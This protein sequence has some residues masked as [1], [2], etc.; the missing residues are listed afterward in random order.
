MGSDD[1]RP[2]AGG[3]C[4]QPEEGL[5][6]FPPTTAANTASPPAERGTVPLSARLRPEARR[7]VLTALL[8]LALTGVLTGLN[9]RRCLVPYLGE[10]MY[11]HDRVR[12]NRAHLYYQ[13]D[14]YLVTIAA[15]ALHDTTGVPLLTIFG[16][17]V[18][19]GYGAALA[20]LAYWLAGVYDDP[21]A[22]A[23]GLV[24]GAVYGA[25]MIPFSYHHPSDMFG[26]GM[27]AWGLGLMVRDRPRLLWLVCLAA[28]LFSIKQM[29]LAP[30]LLLTYALAGRWRRGAWLAVPVVLASEAVPIIYR[31][32][33][34]PHRMSP[35]GIMGISEWLEHLPRGL[36]VQ[37][38]LAGPPLLVLL[39]RRRS[40]PAAVWGALTVY[41]A[42]LLSLELK[43]NIIHEARTFWPGVPG[44]A[45]AL[46]AWGRPRG[47]VAAGEAPSAQRGQERRRK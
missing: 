8:V 10:R 47:A 12:T 39:W 34:G 28:G 17:G 45:A 36:G 4:R 3:G 35:G 43:L 29:L 13:Y 31:L 7:V 25:G 16:V 37:A 41:A 40:V 18:L 2:G 11:M 1:G 6:P 9:V 30:A 21:W 42:L 26:L 27:L 19:L 5:S 32:V 23:L 46:V 20:G 15:Q 22:Q 24:A 44:F 33:L 14:M 38:C